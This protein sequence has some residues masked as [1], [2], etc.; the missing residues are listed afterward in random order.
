MNDWNNMIAGTT[1]Q[2]IEEGEDEI[3]HEESRRQNRPD[4]S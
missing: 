3:P 2:D 4:Q 1:P